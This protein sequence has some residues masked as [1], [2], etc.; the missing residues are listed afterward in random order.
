MVYYPKQKDIIWLDFNPQ[1]GREQANRRPALVLSPSEYNR[2]VGLV[3]VCPTTNQIKG[4]PFEVFLPEKLAV[5]GVILADQIKSFDWRSR[6]AEFIC[7]VPQIVVEQVVD[8]LK[9]LLP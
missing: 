9:I 7:Q 5:S 4:Y 8:R 2:K 1:R 6:N 3:I